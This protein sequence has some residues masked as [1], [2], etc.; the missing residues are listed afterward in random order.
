MSTVIIA[1]G[2][3]NYTYFVVCCSLSQMGSTTTLF[4]SCSLRLLSLN[5]ALGVKVGLRAAVFYG[6]PYKLRPKPKIAAGSEQANG[7]MDSSKVSWLYLHEITTII[8][9]I[10]NY[11]TGQFVM[12]Q[13]M[14]YRG[15]PVVSRS[16]TLPL[17]RVW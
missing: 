6:F 4:C 3:P 5:C 14:S 9:R 7:A 11:S 15:L 1:L 8:T 16:Q 17:K 10:N 2:C 12:L 13:A